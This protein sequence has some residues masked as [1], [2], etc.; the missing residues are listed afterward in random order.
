MGLPLVTREN[1]S[2]Q[3][4]TMLIDY[5]IYGKKNL[6]VDSGLKRIMKDK[7]WEQKGGLF[8]IEE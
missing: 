7:N 6:P 2:S 4:I 3:S 8:F 1:M 5:S